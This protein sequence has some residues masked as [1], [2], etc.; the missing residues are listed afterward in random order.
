MAALD[1]K[2]WE[3]GFQTISDISSFDAENAIPNIFGK[4][5]DTLKTFLPTIRDLYSLYGV[6]KLIED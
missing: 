2:L 4:S 6:Y 5:T 3:N 1:F